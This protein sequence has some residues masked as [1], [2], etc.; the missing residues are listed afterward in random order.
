MD[1][2]ACILSKRKNK[3]YPV[4]YMQDGQN[5]FNEQT[6]FGKEWGVDECLDTLEQQLHKECI[7]VGIDNGSINAL[8]N[9]IRMIMINMVKVKASN[10]RF[11][12]QH[13]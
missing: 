8:M 2:L 4:L 5:L 10:I 1:L 7:V 3:T 13:T 6:A 12:R 9:I 11:Y